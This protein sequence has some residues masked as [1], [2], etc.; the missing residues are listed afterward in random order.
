MLF[1]WFVHNNAIYN[2]F[3]RFSVLFYL[4]CCTKVEDFNT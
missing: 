2:E 4:Y 3:R 1:M